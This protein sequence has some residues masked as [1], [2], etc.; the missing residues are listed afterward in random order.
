MTARKRV[1]FLSNGHGEDRIALAIIHELLLLNQSFDIYGLPL[2]GNGYDYLK[3]ERL[4]VIGPQMETKS[5]G[6]LKGYRAIVGDLRAGILSL[7]FKQIRNARKQSY[8]LI[9]SVGDFLPF[10]VSAFFLRPHKQI[11][12]STAKSDLFEP[13]FGIETF[14]FKMTNTRVFARDEV[15]ALSLQA[16]GVDAEYVGNVMMDLVNVNRS[17]SNRVTTLGVLP[18]SRQEAYV[19]FLRIKEVLLTLPSDWKILLAPPSSLDSHLFDL[20]GFRQGV[21]QVSFEEMLSVVDGV[22][23]LAGTAN[24]Q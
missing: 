11:L 15:T 6:F 2:V 14:G 4:Q 12:I 13:H 19:N 23:G 17:K 16:E 18:G 21:T 9:V 24:E 8:D 20:S 5:G 22:I 7:H 1:L 10:M 3:N